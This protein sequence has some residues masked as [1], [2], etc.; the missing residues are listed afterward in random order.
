MQGPVGFH[1]YHSNALDVLAGLLAAQVARPHAD[2]DWLRPDIVLVPQY[3]MR[4]WLQQTMATIGICANIEFLTPRI[5]EARSMR[6][7]A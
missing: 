1:L 4:R 6:N 3:S 7:S 5:V 2:G